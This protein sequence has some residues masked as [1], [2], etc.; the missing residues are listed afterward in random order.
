MLAIDNTFRPQE[1]EVAPGTMVVWHN[2]GRNRHD[3]LSIHAEWGVTKEEFP[4]D[5]DY[6]HVFDEPGE[7]DYYCSVHGT[8]TIG[9]IGKVIVTA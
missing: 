6:G 3:V 9:M 7:F 4:T 8:P 1:V 5:S 2:A